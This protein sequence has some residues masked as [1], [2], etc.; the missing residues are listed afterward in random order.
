MLVMDD[1]AALNKETGLVWERS[2]E[3]APHA[4][5]VGA[6]EVANRKGW[7]LPMVEQLASLVNTKGPVSQPRR[8]R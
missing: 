7:H 3:A 8:Q 2:P 5:W 1:H 6:I 4:S